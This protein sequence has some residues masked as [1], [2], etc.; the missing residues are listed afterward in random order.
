MNAIYFGSGQ[1]W[2]KVSGITFKDFKYSRAV[3][4]MGASYNEV[5]YCQFVNDTETGQGSG[6]FV[7]GEGAY[8]H[9]IGGVNYHYVSTHNWIH[10]NYL[11]TMYYDDPCGEHTDLM[12]LG[13][14]WTSP[15]DPGDDF[16]TIEDNYLEYAGH[17][18]FAANTHTSVISRNIAHNE[19]FI[20]AGACQNYLQSFPGPFEVGG[21]AGNHPVTASIAFGPSLVG[22]V[23]HVVLDPGIDTMTCPATGAGTAASCPN[24][25]VANRDI[26]LFRP[27]AVPTPSSSASAVG[28]FICG[29]GNS[30]CSST[31]GYNSATGD[32]YFSVS[33]TA[34]PSGTFNDWTFTQHNVPVYDNPEYNGK[35]SH[36]VF[37]IGVNHVQSEPRRN[38]AEDNR[39]GFLGTNPGNSGEAAFLVASPYNLVRY[40]F[41]YG[42]QLSG[43]YFKW[44]DGTS[45]VGGVNTHFYNNTSTH[46]AYGY[47]RAYAGIGGS[48]YGQGISQVNTASNNQIKNNL[49]HDNARGDICGFG[50]LTN[51]CNPLTGDSVVNNWC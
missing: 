46:N 36:R 41:V 39:V 12:L 18:V 9:N 48:V 8:W 32:L 22:T 25:M 45:G 24:I 29:T 43:F 11:S 33:Y 20:P 4:Y 26:V 6:A 42:S 14:S 2:I 15:T 5:S 23:L 38:V 40:N 16:N 17:S 3:F 21:F 10:H 35:F 37:A 19:P 28:G 30:A 49:T 7:I 1:S 51:A 13:Q 31:T 50:G 27:G 47:N 44:A 34:G